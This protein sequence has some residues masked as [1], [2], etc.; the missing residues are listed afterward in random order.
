MRKENI[1]ISV[2][3][4]KTKPYSKRNFTRKKITLKIAVLRSNV[5]S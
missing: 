1:L 5:L 2:K 3:G 4:I